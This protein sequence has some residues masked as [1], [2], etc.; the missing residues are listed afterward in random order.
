MDHTVLLAVVIVGIR[1]FFFTRRGL[2]KF[3]LIVSRLL[4]AFRE[5]YLQSQGGTEL[6][7]CDCKQTPNSC[8]FT[9]QRPAERVQKAP[10]RARS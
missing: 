3:H 8:I 4:E 1:S 10:V 6:I 7:L 2:L 5:K 9:P